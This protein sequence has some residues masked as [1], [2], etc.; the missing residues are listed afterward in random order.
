MAFKERT[1]SMHLRIYEIL[2]SRMRLDK[3]DYYYFLNLRKG[4]EGEC[5]FDGLTE[6]LALKCIILNDL[7]L[8]IRRSSLQID[9]L[10]ICEGKILLYEIKNYGGVHHWGRK[11]LR[12][13]LALLWKILPCN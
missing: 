1:K 5:G 7:Q 3:E 6:K 10:L 9:A 4:H 8:E 2:S 12:S 11:N 13:N